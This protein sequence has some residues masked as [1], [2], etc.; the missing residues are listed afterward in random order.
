[1]L[2]LAMLAL[3]AGLCVPIAVISSALAQGRVGAAALEGIARQPEAAGRI[4]MVMI[5]ALALI[6]SLAIYALLV[7]LIIL[8]VIG[9]PRP[10]QILPLIQPGQ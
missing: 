6:E 7:A 1:M 3:A 8:F 10:D 9:L 5:I 2:Y 4:Q